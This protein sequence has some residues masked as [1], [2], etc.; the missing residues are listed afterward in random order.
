MRIQHKYEQVACRF[1]I[2]LDSKLRE[3]VFL[4]TR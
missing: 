3:L 4:N 2:Y 1:A